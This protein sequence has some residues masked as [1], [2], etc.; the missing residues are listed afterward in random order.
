M[1]AAL[2]KGKVLKNQVLF[3]GGF[4]KILLSW[5]ND[6]IETGFT[7]EEIADALSDLGFPCES[8][9]HLDNDDAV[10]DVEVTSNRG[11]CLGYIGVARELSTV[12]NAK[13]KMPEVNLDESS[14]T[15]SEFI[16]VEINQPDLCNRY[17]VRIIEG[18]KVASSPDWLK[19]RLEAVGIRSVNNV[20]DATNYVMLET[21]QP[22]HAFDFEKINNNK[23]IVRKAEAGDKLTSID[24]S[25]CKLELD[26]LVI[27]DAKCPVAIAG[28]MGGAE[29]EVSEAT[30][31]ILLEDAHFQPLSVRTTSRKLC[32]ASDAS[33]RFERTVDVEMID[34]ASKRTA[35]LIM[36][37]AGGKAARGVVDIYPKKPEQKRVAL[38]IS[39]LNKLLG[40]EIAPSDAVKILSDLGFAP[41]LKDD[42]INCVVPSWRSDVYREVDLIEEVARV[43]GYSNVPSKSKIEIEVVAVNAHQKL[44]ESIGK[45]LAS[46][47]FYETVNVSFVDKTT[48]ELFTK[49]DVDGHLCVKDVSRKS[50]NL[51]RQTLISSLLGV[52]KTNINA[53]NQ[54][55][56]I[57]EIADTFIKSVAAKSGSKFIEKTQLALVCDS[58]FRFLSGVVE[59]L[60]KDVAGDVEI[61][62]RPVDLI[63]AQAGAEILINGDVIGTAGVVNETVIDKFDL[64]TTKPCAAELDF[65]KLMSLQCGA[66]KIKS[67][68]RFPAIERDLSII[69]DEEICWADIALAANQAAS[70][71]LEDIGFIGIYRGKGIEASKKSVTLS[72]RFRDEDGTLTHEVVDGFESAIVDSLA[73]SVAATIRTV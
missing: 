27:A 56:R 53:G 54:P 38:R 15:A 37:V 19:N 11:D 39:R 23:I 51:L 8:I 73:K 32:I 4:M 72:L 42:L 21:G 50:A 22:P 24:E 14:K 49:N 9:E 3:C 28:V 5:L 17:T 44:V 71:Q 60:I 70:S 31:T 61:I 69:V 33:F 13:L 6:Y 65:A 30:T 1:T 41:Q 62:F 29:T 55:C 25:Q 20:V 40:I 66:A 52:F 59:G 68:P 63:W 48:A 67:I 46:G 7:S 26:M 36:Q 18:V 58:D 2:F 57:F 47:G 34:F 16:T 45:Y 35:Q 43:Y 64:K 10:I 12:T